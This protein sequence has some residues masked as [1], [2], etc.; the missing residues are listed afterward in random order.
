M[1]KFAF[2]S[3][4]L[5]PSQ[6]G[7]SMVVYHLLKAFDPAHYCL[8]TLKNFH[9]YK[10]LG[11]C[12][13]Q[14]LAHEYFIH[15]DYQIVRALVAL[16]AKLRFTGLLTL[17]CKIRTCQYVRILKKERCAAVIGCTGIFWIRL[18]RFWQAGNSVYPLSC[19]RSIIIPV[20]GPTRCCGRLP[21]SRKK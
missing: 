3:L 11:N 13:G 5:P 2:I 17:L 16:A 18:Q 12:S 15:P 1:K 10:R 7:Q 8:I 19:M 20:S 9:L 4:G 14:L 21:M 6:S